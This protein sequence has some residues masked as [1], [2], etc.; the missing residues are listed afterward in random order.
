MISRKRRRLDEKIKEGW[1]EGNCRNFE[2][3]PKEMKKEE[4]RRRFPVFNFHT[5]S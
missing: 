1:F 2:D 3:R 4:I 5:L